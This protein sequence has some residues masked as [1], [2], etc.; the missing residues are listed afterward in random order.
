[1]FCKKC[2]KEIPEDAMFCSFC[3]E[4]IKRTITNYDPIFKNG[5]SEEK[6][7][8]EVERLISEG[9]LL[10]FPPDIKHLG[11]AKTSPAAVLQ[12]GHGNSAP[13]PTILAVLVYAADKAP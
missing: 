1:M 13:T 2:G 7:K 9:W 12:S 6:L 3:G 8:A 10:K 5:F 11:R 4:K